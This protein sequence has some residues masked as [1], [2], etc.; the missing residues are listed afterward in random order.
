MHNPE[1]IEE[2]LDFADKLAEFGSPENWTRNE[3]TIMSMA[4]EIRRLR[5]L[6]PPSPRVA[7]KKAK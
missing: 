2:C 5:A 4:K 7:R 6:V 1:N 3:Q